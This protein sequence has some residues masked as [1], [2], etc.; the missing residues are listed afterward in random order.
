MNRPLH[1]I[2]IVVHY[3]D[4]ADCHSLLRADTI[5]S[6]VVLHR[7][8]GP[9]TE[10]NGGE[11]NLYLTETPMEIYEQIKKASNVR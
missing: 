11:G 7:E 6:A 9:L 5:R 2:W 4:S 10:I 1:E 3:V 8:G